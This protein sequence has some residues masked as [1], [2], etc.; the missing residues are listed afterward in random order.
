MELGGNCDLIYG[1]QSLTGKI[2]MSKNLRGEFPLREARNRTIRSR[3]TVTASTMIARLRWR[4]QGQMSQDGCGNRIRSWRIG[5]KKK[6]DPEFPGRLF[7]EATAPRSNGQTVTNCLERGSPRQSVNATPLLMASNTSLA[8]PW[9]V[10]FC[11]Y[12]GFDSGLAVVAGAA[13]LAA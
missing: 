9:V 2:L 8:S 1:A 13:W 4:A 6:A 11:P 3:R 12:H 10:L 5:A 7:D